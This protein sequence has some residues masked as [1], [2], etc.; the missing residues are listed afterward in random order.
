MN[1]NKYTIAM[2]FIFLAGCARQPEQF[3]QSTT[4]MG[5]LLDQQL[6]AYPILEDNVYLT[7]KNFE[8]V[9]EVEGFSLFRGDG[10]NADPQLLYSAS[11]TATGTGALGIAFD[12]VD[13]Y[14]LV[15][16]PPIRRW[17]A[18]N[19]L[20]LGIF[21]EEIQQKCDIEIADAAGKTIK[22]PFSLTQGWNK[23]QIDLDDVGRKIDIE[24]IETM[25]FSFR[26]IGDTRIFIDDLILIDDQKKTTNEDSGKPVKK[27][28]ISAPSWNPDWDQNDL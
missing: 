28:T 24:K 2:I 10:S 18:Y 16:D 7:L 27:D 26:R 4:A 3:S 25:R 23:L 5:T 14:V 15:F 12:E 20:L 6:A 21:I 9:R 11:P 1:E 22:I 19:T 13:D 8:F 17:S